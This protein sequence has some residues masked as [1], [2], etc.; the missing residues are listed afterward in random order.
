M[1]SDTP[2]LAL[3]AVVPDEV[4][5]LLEQLHA[6]ALSE[7][8]A[9]VGVNRQRLCDGLFGPEPAAR[10]HWLYHGAQ[11]C[12]FAL[13]SWKWG[14]FTGTRDLYLHALYLDPA[15]RRRG[16]GRAA[17]CALAELAL[18]AGSTRMEWLSVRSVDASA[19]FYASLGASVADHMMVQRLDRPAMHALL[20]PTLMTDQ[21]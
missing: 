4:D 20:N 1:N 10:V 16:L 15:F 14:A 3:R 17:M 9:Q 2:K 6:L 18:A 5:A 13:H 12:G 19:A 7:G 11:R 21:P 8:V